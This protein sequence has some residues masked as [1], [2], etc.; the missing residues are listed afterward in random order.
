MKLFYQPVMR[1]TCLALLTV[2]TNLWAQSPPPGMVAAA[3]KDPNSEW[4][5][6]PTR[7]LD[8]FP[9]EV[10][11]K[12]DSGLSPYGGLS[13]GQNQRHRFFSRDETG[14]TL[15]V[16]GS[17]R[18]F[19]PVSRSRQHQPAA[20]LRRQSRVPVE[21]PDRDELGRANKSELLLRTRLYRGRC[22]V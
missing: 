12:M 15:V 2:A 17:G 18:Q 10:R 9:A 7:T 1:F 20:N 4:K 19:V 21:V 16:G 6:Y 13:D 11:E 8:N 22:L 3:F 5:N 14:R